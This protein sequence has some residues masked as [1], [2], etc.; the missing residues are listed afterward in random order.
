MNEISCQKLEELRW[1]EA[2]FGSL[3]QAREL[4]QPENFSS[5]S[6]VQEL[7]VNC[8]SA[9]ERM[10]LEWHKLRSFV[11]IAQAKCHHDFVKFHRAEKSYAE[12]G[13]VSGTVVVAKVCLHCKLVLG[14]D[15]SK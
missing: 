8:Q 7:L 6:D 1:L 13:N 9:V 4:L 14:N 5:D 2:F 10:T 12:A 11:E 15:D 3:G